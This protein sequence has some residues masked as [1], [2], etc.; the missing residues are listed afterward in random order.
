[1]GSTLLHQ[2]TDIRVKRR[3]P[4]ASYP[5]TLIDA[6]SSPLK[7]EYAVGC[8]T[9]P[10]TAHTDAV[11]DRDPSAGRRMSEIVSG[12]ICKNVASLAC[13][14]SYMVLDHAQ[15]DPEPMQV[16]LERRSNLQCAH[17]GFDLGE[18]SLMLGQFGPSS[19]RA[20]GARV[21]PAPCAAGNTGW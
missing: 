16:D 9:F 1:M 13:H 14:S 12:Y 3:S 20:S 21:R 6:W 19:P 15:V 2:A 7:I 5:I 4:L 11:C 18:P 10:L 8:G 17:D